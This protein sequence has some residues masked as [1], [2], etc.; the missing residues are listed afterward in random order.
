M[1]IYVHDVIDNKTIHGRFL[2]VHG[3]ENIASIQQSYTRVDFPG[4]VKIILEI[5][6][7]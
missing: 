3:R 2:Q 7:I 1:N 4:G 5:I 6:G